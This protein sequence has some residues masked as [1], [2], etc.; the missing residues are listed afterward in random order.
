MHLRACS[1]SSREVVIGTWRQIV[2]P[3]PWRN[4]VYWFVPPVTKKS[5]LNPLSYTPAGPLAASITGIKKPPTDW[6][7]GRLPNRQPDREGLLLGE[8]II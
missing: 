6:E 2:M 1:P 7:L 3:R 8:H 5:S 4:T